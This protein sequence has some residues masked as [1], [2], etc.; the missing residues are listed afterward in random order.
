MKICPACGNHLID[1]AI[2][3]NNCGNRVE[4]EVS[5]ERQGYQESMQEIPPYQGGNQ[6]MQGN[7]DFTYNVDL[8]FC[9]DTTGSMRPVLDLVKTNAL[10]FYEDL[11]SHMNEKDKVISRLRIR[12][13]AFKDYLACDLDGT[14]PMLATDFF[15][16]PDDSETFRKCVDSL[17]PEGGGDEPEDGLEALAYA[18]RSNWDE[19]GTG[20]KRRQVIVV[21]TD[22]STHELGYGSKSPKYPKNNMPQNFDEL[23]DW[24]GYGQDSGKMNQASKRL[25]LYA[26]NRLYWSTISDTWDN[27]IH[28]PSR[29]GEGLQEVEYSQIIDTIANSI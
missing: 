25:L 19:G 11:I 7:Y 6:S 4:V 8:V 1:E 9:I 27:V 15:V 29:A 24:W 26:P 14:N 22:A 12:I 3:C 18:M 21:W 28:F 17:F 20:I 13:I 5:S 2:F 16:L 23:S 10:N